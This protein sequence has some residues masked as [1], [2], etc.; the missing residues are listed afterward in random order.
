MQTF[1]IEGGTVFCFCIY[2]T[3]IIFAIL[4]S[5]CTKGPANLSETL[6]WC[7]RTEGYKYTSSMTVPEM[8][9]Q[10]DID[11][12]T[13]DAADSEKRPQGEWF[14]YFPVTKQSCY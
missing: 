12:P 14:H 13:E 9:N 6:R 3:Y 4:A 8:K 11:E 2:N 10:S 5:A 1:V 7:S